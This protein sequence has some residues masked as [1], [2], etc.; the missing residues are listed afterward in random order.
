VFT[1]RQRF[2]NGDTVD[3]A[4]LHARD[5]Y[6]NDISEPVSWSFISDQMGPAASE[7]TPI[8]DTT[9][10]ETYCTISAKI[11]DN[12]TQV[13]SSSILVMITTHYWSNVYSLESPALVWNGEYLFFYPESLG[14]SFIPGDTITVQIIRAN[15]IPDY[16][17]P[18]SFRFETGRWRFF[19]ADEDTLQPYFDNFS[20]ESVFSGREFY[21]KVDIMDS[22]GI[23]VDSASGVPYIMWDNDGEL[24]F[25]YNL[26]RLDSLPGTYFVDSAGRGYGWRFITAFAI[27]PQSETAQFVYRVY[28]CDNDFDLDNPGDRSCG[29]SEIRRVVILNTT[30]PEISLITPYE[31]AYSSCPRQQIKIRIYDPQGVDSS[32]IVFRVMGRVYTLSS[33]E[34]TYDDSI[35]TFTPLSAYPEGRVEFGIGDVSDM[36]GNVT[37]GHSWWF[38]LDQTPPVLSDLYPQSGQEVQEFAPIIRFG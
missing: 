31:G 17:E 14:L 29:I 22:S 18:N 30:G 11:T 37:P 23:Y 4:L 9:L 7:L 12:F 3:I 5:R 16:G 34:I 36:L 20:P 26:I 19:I 10:T 33:P 25:T 32:T 6:Y 15:D 38:I 28:A 8:P 1:P 13:D 21:I 35:L 24:S 27:P 2:V